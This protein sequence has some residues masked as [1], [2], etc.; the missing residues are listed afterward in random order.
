V[1]PLA[2]VAGFI[3]NFMP[4]VLPVI[5]LKLMAFVQQ[6]GDSR[7]RV[8]TLNVSYTLG[9]MSVFMVLATM[10][11]IFEKTWG[12]Q[13]SNAVFNIVLT[14]IVFA[15]ALSFLDV[16]EI[17]IPGF[18]GSGK[19]SEL[20]QKEGPVGA[21]FMGVLATVLATPCS[22][23]LLV[24]ALAW[25]VKQPPVVSYGA[26]G[27]AALGMASP[28]LLIGVFPSLISFLPKP[29]AWMETFRQ[30]MGFALFVAVVWLLTFI[31]V[32]Y[33]VPT[34]AFLFG[35]W[36]ACWWI[37]RTPPTASLDKKLS[38][39]IQA[40]VAA[41]L[42]GLVSFGWLHGVMAGRFQDAVDRELKQRDIE[43]AQRRP[44]NASEGA[45]LPW[46]PYSRELL[47]KLTAERKTVFVDFTADW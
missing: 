23:P 6:A 1:L 10:V 12:E 20:S 28:Y 27:C 36:A 43:V 25:A 3:L 29:G 5:G 13:F 40:S 33:V 21:F 46:R 7:G 14:S 37:G 24:P 15:F 30:L 41:A 18:V 4:C 22:G 9:L 47:E 19:A 44:K 39:W 32:P 11:V 26:F 2:L 16:W 17:P 45:E 31:A 35:L 8:L 34:V 42:I 38:V